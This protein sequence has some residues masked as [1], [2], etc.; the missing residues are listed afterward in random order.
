[1]TSAD[2]RLP[3]CVETQGLADRVVAEVWAA[4]ALGVEERADSR[5]IELFIYLAGATEGAIR[6]A[7]E[8]FASEGA[9]VGASQVIG[10]LDWREAWKEGLE[11]I[12]ISPRLVIRPS[13]IEHARGPGQAEVVVDPGQA[14][15]TGGH[16][17]TR[18][19]LEWIDA[20]MGEEGGAPRVLDVGTGSG[21]LALSALRLG[22]TRAVGFDLDRDAIAEARDSARANGL[23]PRFDC[24]AGPIACLGGAVFDLVLANL[25][26][27][28]VLP[29]A[30]EI[31]QSLAPG[32]RL[33]LSGLVESDRGAVLEGFAGNGL[34]AGSERTRRDASGVV[35]IAP[36]LVA[37][38]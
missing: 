19:A 13:F 27:S 38:G 14:F 17:S 29:I 6:T 9:E 36:L 16:E 10:D 7:L 21:V 3:V 30:R 8:P 35:W 24:F 33:V 23:A 26:R 15:G 37:R 34:A 11:A 18:L 12:V 4:G 5:R 2:L 32:G 1:M 31:A 25:L 20:L 22:A 28:E